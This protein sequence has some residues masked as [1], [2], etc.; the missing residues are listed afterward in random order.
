[1]SQRFE[2]ID[3]FLIYQMYEW[4]VPVLRIA[5]GIVFL[6]FGALKVLDVSPVVA[7][8]ASVY[9]F[10]PQPFFIKFLG[11]WEMII[12]IGLI[13][14][15]FLRTTLFLLWAQMMGTFVSLFLAPSL[16]FSGLNPLML[17]ME[18]EFIVKNIVLSVSGIVIGGHEVKQIGS[19]R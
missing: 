9:S 8:V 2:R 15:L 10:L 12:G 19:H 14:K 16:F 13:F 3:H 5:L 17:T 4:G 11:I 7:L 1:M 6:W 18:G